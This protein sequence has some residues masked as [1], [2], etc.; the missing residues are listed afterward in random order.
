[1]PERPPDAKV[2]LVTGAS[3][4]IGAATARAF[5]LAGHAVVLAARD[6]GK[7]EAVIAGLGEAGGA[8]AGVPCDVTDP[9][10]VEAL[11][12]RVRD[13]HGR[14]DVVFNNAGT[15]VP[16]ALADYLALVREFDRRQGGTAVSP[17]PAPDY[18]P[19]SP[20]L[21]RLVA[22]AQDRLALCEKHPEEVAA[23]RDELGGLTG[24]S[25]HETDGYGALRAMLP[26]PERRALVLIDP[27]FEAQ[28]EFAQ[29]TAAREVQRHWHEAWG[30]NGMCGECRRPTDLAVMRRFIDASNATQLRALHLL[31][32]DAANAQGGPEAS[33][34][35]EVTA[36][37][38]WLGRRYGLAE[39]TTALLAAAYRAVARLAAGPVDVARV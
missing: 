7:M 14:L 5:A 6:G 3:Q 18:Y 34:D 22:R 8:C 4:G 29:M 16:A 35:E 9:G 36:C 19:G 2:V 33:P 12:A 32:P 20:W 15:N 25:V 10:S 11:F 1:M 30:R 23:L 24:V 31:A 37:L 27:P 21:M 28:D 17:A 38:C 13:L 26:P 39:T